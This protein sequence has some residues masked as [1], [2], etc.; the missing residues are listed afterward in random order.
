MNMAANTPIR[1]LIVDDEAC[2][3]DLL[4]E[5]LRLLSYAPTQC[6]SPIAALKLLEEREFEV[7]LSDFRMPHMNGDEFYHKAIS[8]R[9]DLACKFV[10]LTGDSMNEDTQVFLKEHSRPHLSKPFD[11]ESV[12]QVISQV[13]EQQQR[14]AVAA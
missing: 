3:S 14:G 13:L 9:R 1:V 5:M 2:I 6:F 11:L 7:I 4:A 10:F 12:V 8:L